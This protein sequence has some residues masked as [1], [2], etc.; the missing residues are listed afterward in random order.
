MNYYHG[1]WNNGAFIGFHIIGFLI[2]VALVIMFIRFCILGR[3]YHHHN[4]STGS[5]ES[6]IEI[7][8]QRY[9]KGEVS[10]DEYDKLLNDL[11]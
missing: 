3:F 7:V 4:I 11:K 8:K 10:K 1:T 5:S 2:F 9:A 6:A